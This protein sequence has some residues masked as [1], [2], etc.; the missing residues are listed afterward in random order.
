M[1]FKHI[2]DYGPD[3]DEYNN[4]VNNGKHAFVLIFME[5]CGPCSETLPKWKNIEV[6]MQGKYNRPNYN[7]VIVASI[8]KN[9]LDKVNHIGNIEGFPTMKYIGKNGGIVEPYEESKIVRKDRST[10]SFINWIEHIMGNHYSE[11]PA[12]YRKGRGTKTKMS[13]RS[14]RSKRN[15]TTQKYGKNQKRKINKNNKSKNKRK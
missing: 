7:D 3:L 14:N 4:Y 1:I 15:K 10:S 2:N 8:N 5:G 6:E 9:L 13:N 11:K 12:S